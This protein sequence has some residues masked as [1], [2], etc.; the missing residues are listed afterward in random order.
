[1]NLFLST[2][3]NFLKDNL[4]IIPFYIIAIWL[5]ALSGMKVNVIETVIIFSIIMMANTFF[6]MMS[7]Y[8]SKWDDR[9]W[10][11]MF[12]I[13]NTLYLITWIYSAINYD[14]WIYVTNLFIYWTL[15]VVTIYNIFFNKNKLILISFN[16]MTVLSILFFISTFILSTPLSMLGAAI[17]TVIT[18]YSLIMSNKTTRIYRNLMLLSQVLVILSAVADI[19]INYIQNVPIGWINFAY[20]VFPITIMIWLL[21]NKVAN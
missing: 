18:G 2:L 10:W 6:I 14:L 12:I 3:K 1:M 11:L 21:K 20:I 8:F 9:M 7:T 17:C 15:E 4:W 5:V 13:A 19:V 16:T